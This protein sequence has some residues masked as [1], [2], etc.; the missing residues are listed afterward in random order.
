MQDLIINALPNADIVVPD[1]LIFQ[2]ANVTSPSYLAF[3]SFY[4]ASN[5]LLRLYNYSGSLNVSL[6]LTTVTS[7]LTMT[8]NTLATANVTTYGNGKAKANALFLN[9]LIDYPGFFLNTDG[10]LSADKFLQDSNTYHNYSYVIVVEKALSQYKHALMQLAHPAGMSMLG[11]FEIEN[12][13]S[14]DPVVEGEVSV[15]PVV[16]GEVFVNAFDSN[17][18]LIGSGFGNTTINSFTQIA[19]ANQS[20]FAVVQEAN[21]ASYSVVTKNGLLQVPT[22]QYTEANDVFTFT[23]NCRS[24]DEVEFK[25]FSGTADSVLLSSN[26]YISNANQSQFLVTTAV[27]NEVY[28]LATK[29]GLLQAP[30]VDYTLNTVTN[31]VSFTANCRF[32][33]VVEFRAFTGN[34]GITGNVTIE[35]TV[36]TATA[37]QVL[38]ELPDAVGDANNVIV[39]RNGLLQIPN[40]QYSLIDEV[41]VFLASNSRVGDIVE[42]RSFTGFVGS[43]PGTEFLETANAGDLITFNTNDD[44][45]P[46]FTKIIEEVVSNNMLIMESNTQY[47]FFNLVSVSVNSNNI[48]T[49]DGFFG[50][51]GLTDVVAM[52]VAGALI[53]SLVTSV[54][55]SILSTNNT[56]EANAT[57]LVMLVYPSINNAS[58]VITNR[59][60]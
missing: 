34:V 42:C 59:A 8:V 12:D 2:G 50:N 11:T 1:E 6:P 43:G 30:F 58:Y 35:S 55:D 23:A 49:Q 54:S 4:N 53:Y 25:I 33:D 24:G 7:N 10:F 21:T 40:Q 9:G 29:N 47:A 37:N 52:N 26:Y 51:V 45:R 60:T 38:F 22:L 57:N 14:D 5:T 27:L 20:T 46:Q 36:F 18:I 39:T 3:V 32:G 16:S 56:F 48:T 13:I 41:A 28:L 19:S 31:I 44:S 15:L 17:Y